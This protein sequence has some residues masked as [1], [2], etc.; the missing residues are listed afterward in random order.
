[1]FPADSSVSIRNKKTM[2]IIT[3]L[4]FRQF[5]ELIFGLSTKKGD[6]TT[7]PFYFN[8]SLSVGDNPENVKKNRQ[9]FYGGLGLAENKVVLQKQTHSDI[10]TYVDKPGLIGESDAMITDIKG[11]GLGISVADCTPVFLFDRKNKVIAAIHSGWRGTQKKIVL[12]TLRK[13][14]DMYNSAPEDIYAY[15]GPSINQKN[16]EVGREV[17]LQFESEYSVPSG[18]KF[19]LDVR[20][21]N[22]DMLLNYGIPK[23]QIQISRLCTYEDDDILHSYR[24]DGAASGRHLGIIALKG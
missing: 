21:A 16:Y 11:L 24:R 8:L 3:S 23:K 7:V 13:L 1:M 2:V 20:K 17:A 5:P 14:K 12:K 4:I 19:L 6:D 18:E 9:E 15:I 10:C 22:S